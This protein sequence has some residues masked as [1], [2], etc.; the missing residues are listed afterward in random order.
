MRETKSKRGPDRREHG[1][2]LFG[3]TGGF[4]DRASRTVKA[5]D[6]P[7]KPEDLR[8]QVCYLLAESIKDLTYVR[9][10][11]CFEFPKLVK[12]SLNLTAC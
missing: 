8:A 9:E 4:F 1:L 10:A 3:S 2:R 11:L 12:L 7:T 5:C 6:Q